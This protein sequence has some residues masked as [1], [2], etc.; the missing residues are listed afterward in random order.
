MIKKILRKIFHNFWYKMSSLL[1]ALLAWGLIQGEQVLEVHRE[2][3]INL[4][5]PEGYQI[6]GDV[7][8]SVAA[9]VK[10]P[11][12][13]LLEAPNDLEIDIKVPPLE[14]KIYR[15]RLDKSDI[16]RWDDRLQLQIHDPYISVFVDEKATRT[17]PVK[18]VPF[19]TPADGY[20]V[21]KVSLN[22]AWVKITG[23]K[24][25][26]AKVR[27]VATEPVDITGIQQNQTIEIALLPP[28]NFSLSD[29]ATNHVSVNL[30]VADSFVNKR[31]GGIPIEVV[32]SDFEA[33]VRPSFASI[34]IQGTPGVLKFVNKEDLKAFV[35]AR[36]LRPGIYEAEIKVKIPPETV[37]IE[38]FP[39][40]GTLVIEKRRVPH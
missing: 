17:V 7:Q 15:A 38:A 35:E 10:G 29:L 3:Q 31:F 30:Q 25:E 22:P 23:L 36:G 27:E 32:G 9:T 12:V 6:R 33:K 20:F 19:G 16:K 18:Y 28:P 37:M 13:L 26:L 11:R 14:G 39:E 1:L 21:K 40:K 4:E 5:V 24:S 34:V 2:I 8:R